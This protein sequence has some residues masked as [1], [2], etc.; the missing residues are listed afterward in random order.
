MDAMHFWLHNET[1]KFESECRSNEQRMRS[2]TTMRQVRDLGM[3]HVRSEISFMPGVR[4]A[5]THL[6][7]A[8]GNR[9]QALM[10]EDL[11]TLGKIDNPAEFTKKSGQLHQMEWT[12]L[13][14]DYANVLVAGER[15]IHR[16]KQTL[17]KKLEMKIETKA[18]ILSDSV[19]DEAVAKPASSTYRP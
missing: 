3:A 15:E 18:E 13:R 6:R 14:G 10:E 5:K 4:S 17:E 8:A 7:H 11:A 9:M 1:Q 19:S 2:A 12:F 16:L